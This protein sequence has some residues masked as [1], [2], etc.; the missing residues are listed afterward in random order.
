[1]MD[2]CERPIAHSKITMI[3]DIPR[4]DKAAKARYQ[5][6]YKAKDDEQ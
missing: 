5:C 6:G 3:P 2:K 4:N 1:M